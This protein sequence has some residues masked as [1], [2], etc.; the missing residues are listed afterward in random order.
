MLK[1]IHHKMKI[2]GTNIYYEYYHHP[3]QT[4]TIVLIHGFLSS[5]FSYRKLI[6]LLKKHF[7]II[8]IDL[9]PFGKSE[10]AT[11]FFY[12]Y[13][14]MAKAVIELLERLQIK[15]AVIVGHS[16]GGQISLYAAKQK[17]DL[18]KKLCSFAALV[19]CKRCLPL[20]YFV[21]ISRIFTFTLKDNLSGK[22]YGKA[23]AVSCTTNRSL[24]KT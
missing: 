22:A 24:T 21:H 1:E 10:K 13:H 23:Y 8:A 18:F 12:S 19:I 3:Q 17:P 5:T 6:P 11:K 2:L 16:M 9:P 20:S 15:Q 4:D 14:N 7:S